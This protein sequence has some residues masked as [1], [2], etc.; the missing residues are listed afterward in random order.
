MVWTTMWRSA[1]MAAARSGGTA[2]PVSLPSV[3]RIRTLS[4]SVARS[5]C[6]IATPI[7]SPMAVFGPAMPVATWSSNRVRV[8]WSCVKGACG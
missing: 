6:L 7:A 8:A 2:L 3:N 4:R 1:A 5:N